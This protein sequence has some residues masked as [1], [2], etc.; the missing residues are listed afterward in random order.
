MKFWAELEIRQ[1]GHLFRRSTTR[2]DKLEELENAIKL[3]VK[4]KHPEIKARIF[5]NQI[6]LFP[7]VIFKRETDHNGNQITL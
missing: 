4:N 7:R 2:F 5:E 6:C 3:D 1:S